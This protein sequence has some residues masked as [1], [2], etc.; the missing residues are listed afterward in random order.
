MVSEDC[1]Y[2]VES[3]AVHIS[4][5]RYYS[6]QTVLPCRVPDLY[7]AIR[8]RGFDSLN[9]HLTQQ[10]VN[11]IRFSFYVCFPSLSVKIVRDFC[12]FFKTKL[13]HLPTHLLT[14]RQHTLKGLLS[15]LYG[16]SKKSAN[17][18][19]NTL[20]NTLPIFANTLLTHFKYL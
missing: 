4:L 18:L 10:V 20:A 19:T 7:D 12:S 15:V 17:T 13:T 6:Y 9:P 5:E 2:S 8:P 16:D 14:H 11:R 1:G 3:V